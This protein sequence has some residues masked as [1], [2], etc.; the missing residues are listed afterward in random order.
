MRL[1]S[2]DLFIGAPEVRRAFLS[3]RMPEGV[4]VYDVLLGRQAIDLY[5]K[6]SRALA[7]PARIRLELLSHSGCKVRFRMRSLSPI[8]PASQIVGELLQA[9]PD[10]AGNGRDIVEIDLVQMSGGWVRSLEITGINIDPG[11]ITLSAKNIDLS[12]DW[13]NLGEHTITPTR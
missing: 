1:E 10:A 11:G 7:I 13:A 6:V 4:T 9:T 2:V 3:A 12:L 5:V 8:A